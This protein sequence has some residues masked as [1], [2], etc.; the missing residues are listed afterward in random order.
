MAAALGLRFE[1]CVPDQRPARDLISAMAAETAAVLGG[2]DGTLGDQFA[3]AELTDA[4]GGS[5]LVGWLDDEPVAGGGLRRVDFQTAEIKRMYVAPAWRGRGYGAA[6]LA[7][8][9]DAAQAR[10]CCVVRLDAGAQQI[11]ALRLYQ[12]CGYRSVSPYNDDRYASFWG[13]KQLD[14]PSP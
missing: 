8:L 10:G 9:E 4:T 1:A 13:E 11:A 14:P 3:A 5:Y 7:A 2:E 12:R 6:L